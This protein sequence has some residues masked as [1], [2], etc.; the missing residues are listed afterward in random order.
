M[1]EKRRFTEKEF[2]AALLFVGCPR[3]KT[4]QGRSFRPFPNYERFFQVPKSS[5]SV[6]R[7]EARERL[8]HIENRNIEEYRN[9]DSVDYEE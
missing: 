5:K 7:K 3:T 9:A 2:A 6:R 4:F 1:Q 8:N